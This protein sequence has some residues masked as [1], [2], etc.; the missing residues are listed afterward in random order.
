MSRDHRPAS[1]NQA[2]PAAS[3]LTPLD[4]I[5]IEPLPSARISSAAAGRSSKSAERAS[6]IYSISPSARNSETHAP[7]PQHFD[8][9]VDPYSLDSSYDHA[10]ARYVTVSAILSRSGALLP[11]QSSEA[12]FGTSIFDE[13]LRRRS[14]R[15]SSSS[16][17][18]ALSKRRKSGALSSGNA[19]EALGT[20]LLHN[21]SK[22][23]ASSLSFQRWYPRGNR[24][25]SVARKGS[26][27]YYRDFWQGLQSIGVPS[28]GLRLPDAN[29]NATINDGMTKTDTIAQ[30]R[31][32]KR[33]EDMSGAD[34]EVVFVRVRTRQNQPTFEV[35]RPA[36][37]RSV[38]EQTASKDVETPLLRASS[39][40]VYGNGSTFG[41]CDPPEAPPTP[42]GMPGD[43]LGGSGNGGPDGDE[44]I[45]LLLPPPLLDDRGSDPQSFEGLLGI[46]RAREQ[47]EARKR[48][49]RLAAR[50]RPAHKVGLM[51]ALT[52]FVKAAHAADQANRVV[53]AAG[54]NRTRPGGLYRRHT[55][56]TKQD[57]ESSYPVSDRTRPRNLVLPGSSVVSSPLAQPLDQGIHAWD[58]TNSPAM[59]VRGSLDH[60][61]SQTLETVPEDMSLD[62]ASERSQSFSEGP[63]VAA[64]RRSSIALRETLPHAPRLLPI[65]MSLPPSPFTPLA[66]SGSGSSRNSD[67]LSARPHNGASPKTSLPR[68]PRINPT[69]LS[70]PPSP[71]TPHAG[72]PEPQNRQSQHQSFALALSVQ[73][74]SLPGTP[75]LAPS[76]LSVMPSPLAS[77][78][79]STMGSP[80]AAVPFTFESAA[81]QMM[82]SPSSLSLDASPLVPATPSLSGSDVATGLLRPEPEISLASKGEKQAEPSAMLASSERSGVDSP[83]GSPQ[84]SFLLW[85]LMG[86]LGLTLQS[87][88]AKSTSA[89]FAIDVLGFSTFC[90]VHLVD[91]LYEIKDSLA[92]L[93]WFLRWV[94]LNLT[95]QTVLSRCILEAYSLIQAEWSLVAEEDHEQ[96]I[97]SQNSTSGDTEKPRTAGLTR[98]QVIRGFVELICLHSV[99]RSRWIKEGAGLQPLEGWGKSS[100]RKTAR[101]P[102]VAESGIAAEDNGYTSSDDADE[103]DDDIDL[104]VTRREE[105]ILEFT[106]TPRLRPR[107]A[108][109]DE[110]SSKIGYFGPIDDCKSPI[111]RSSIASGRGHVNGLRPPRNRALI[112]TLK[113][114]S[115]LA[116]GAYGLH[117][118]IVD[119]PPTF[120]PS[121][122]RFSQQTFAHLS[123]LNN[124]EDVLHADIQQIAGGRST[125]EEAEEGADGV[126][127]P[128]QPTFYVARDHVRKTIVVA[129]RG[130]QS[131]SDVIADLDMRTETFPLPQHHYTEQEQ[132]HHEQLLDTDELTCHAGVL[133]AAQ[134][135]LQP[136]SSLM[137]ALTSALDDHKDF[138]L[139]FVGH[140][141][142]AAIASAIVMLLGRYSSASTDSESQDGGDDTWVIGPNPGGLPEG[143]S[144][145][146]ISFAPP[147]TFSAALCR[148]A[149]KGQTP[150]VLSVVLGA[151]LIPRAGHGQARELR[152]L[153]GALARVRRRHEA[154]KE[155]KKGRE[156][157]EG[158]EEEEDARV[159]I[160]R[161][162]WKW[163]KLVAKASGD[164]NIRSPHHNYGL[165]NDE[166][167]P[168]PSRALSEPER[169]LKERIESQLWKLRCDVEADLYS[170]IK[171]R[172]DVNGNAENTDEAP[173]GGR[174]RPVPPS[175]WIGPHG[176]AEAPLHQ[177]AERR[178]AL[179]AATLRS[180]AKLGGVLIPAGKVIYIDEA[181]AGPSDSDQVEWL[182][183]TTPRAKQ[184]RH[185]LYVVESPLSFFSLPE[186]T[187]S[188]FA[189]HLPS[190][191]EAVLEDL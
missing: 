50:N 63:P 17:D 9:K 49:E 140:S 147:A 151:D 35:S 41:V 177:L 58:S 178:Q 11:A 144:I 114:A 18:E 146:A 136:S 44:D 82:A 34:D 73:D 14:G 148:R 98:L 137:N 169:H 43:W 181:E 108:F 145:R 113:W 127:A 129:V 171:A 158:E 70:L 161:S 84:R 23:R 94:F 16:Q 26:T 163:S 168:R 162:W 72:G 69:V 100:Q 61:L 4:D 53:A 123:R 87:S 77:Q 164:K 25:E 62:E 36:M 101:P 75:R 170:A 102:T 40:A 31:A 56:P 135:L 111:R 99:T 86:D 71:W 96:R 59:S 184:S 15:A 81:V 156:E 110:S 89:S 112:R 104:V 191:Y 103:D 121:G 190:S 128:Y 29:D 74:L 132:Q 180:E 107:T 22:G 55:E 166:L 116:I 120:T 6:E 10:Q 48:L 47:E 42:L 142:G 3:H 150:L 130:T 122:E 167:S 37:R 179:D 52:N 172:A 189:S 90:L 46:R 54:R 57:R 188:L 119:L 153:L 64:S 92:L 174:R 109:G 79:N 39:S 27:R 139:A 105:D 78:A 33:L 5:A 157:A 66:T 138:G 176:R 118:H 141:L 65:Q 32:K 93:S 19:L 60:S 134:S 155:E 126:P 76:H 125:V 67:Y 124:P 187:T 7:H 45:A 175:P 133:R 95:G 131:F 20:L 143:R 115:R 88:L 68:A 160:L 183:P 106:R 8:D 149:A 12:D 21:D 80:L 51:T 186:F 83:D 152:R 173:S 117:V 38:T 2:S 91:L 1:P 85:W 28:F 185:R 97:M 154:S 24:N 159:H 182:G 165:S 30:R 13:G